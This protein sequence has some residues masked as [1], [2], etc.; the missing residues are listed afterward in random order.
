MANYSNDF[1]EFNFERTIK[2][3]SEKKNY[4]EFFILTRQKRIH[5]GTFAYFSFLLE[6]YEL[7]LQLL[8]NLELYS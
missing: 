5:L 7:R 1:F 4:I 8:A 3:L 6:I 2:V